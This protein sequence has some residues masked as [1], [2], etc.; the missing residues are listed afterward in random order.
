M[1]LIAM[2]PEKESLPGSEKQPAFDKR[3]GLRAASERHLYMAGHVVRPF[4]G[5]CEAG[6]VFG[7][8]SLHETLQVAPSGWVC[9]FHKD[10]TATGMAAEYA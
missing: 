1:R 4:V 10:Q 5:V 7:Y 9:V 6:I 2:L 3:D 8:E